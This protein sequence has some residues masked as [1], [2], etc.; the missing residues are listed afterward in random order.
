VIYLKNASC[1]LTASASAVV[2]PLLSF[3]FLIDSA[4]AGTNDQ[5]RANLR[6]NSIAAAL[7]VPR[8][9]YYW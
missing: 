2:K 9:Q 3:L 6:C 4:M 5:V 8:S 1:Y 7:V